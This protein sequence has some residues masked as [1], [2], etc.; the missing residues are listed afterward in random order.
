[1]GTSFS[2][3]LF[4][5]GKQSS[6]AVCTSTSVI[7]A[8]SGSIDAEAMQLHMHDRSIGAVHDLRG[9]AGALVRHLAPARVP[10]LL[11]RLPQAAVP[12][13]GAHQPDPAP[14][15]AAALVHE[16]RALVCPF[17]STCTITDVLSVL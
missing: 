7:L 6:G 3:N 16:H 15:A 4:I 11:L 14:G 5:W 8:G 12:A 2:L 17:S 10:R 13:P 9:D 1:M